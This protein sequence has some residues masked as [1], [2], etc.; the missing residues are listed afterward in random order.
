MPMALACHS[1]TQSWLGLASVYTVT[2][3]VTLNIKEM[4]KGSNIFMNYDS[5][6][7]QLYITLADLFKPAC[8]E[9]GTNLRI[10][11]VM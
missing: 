8:N 4:R 10:L 1:V 2:R 9:N 7:D 6:L 5:R 3:Q 11:T